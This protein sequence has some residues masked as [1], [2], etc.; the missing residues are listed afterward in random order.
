MKANSKFYY[1]VFIFRHALLIALFMISDNA[2]PQIYGLKFQNHDVVLDKR[3]EL[4]LSPDRFLNFNGEFE[5]SFDFNIYLLKPNDYSGLFG[6]IFRIIS[7]ENNNIDLLISPNPTI[8]LNLVIG[9]TDSVIHIG[10][11]NNALDGWINLRVKFLLNE[12]RLIFYTP[13]SFY[14]QENVGFKRDDSF[15]IIF[16][17]NDYGNFKTSDVPSMIIKDIRISEEGNLKYHW[18]LDEEE[19]N[20]AGNRLNKAVALVKNPIWIKNNHCKWETRY[21]DEINGYVLVASDN[22]NG[23]IFLVGDRE[24]LIYSAQENIIQSVKYL[25]KS[26]SINNN[27]S[28]IYNSLDN[29]IYC[30]IIN[31]KVFYSLDVLTGEWTEIDAYSNSVSFYRHY[32]SF[33]N[34]DEN[35]IYIFGGYGQHSYHNEIRKLDLTK[36][37]WQDLTVDNDI[38]FPRYLTGLG[39]LNDTVYLLGGFGSLTGSQLVNPHSFFDLL[40]YSIKNRAFFKKFE[41]TRIYDDM[42]VGNTMWINNKNRDYYALIFEKI[43]FESS[44]QLIKGNI[45][46]PKVKFLGDRIPFKFLD[47]RSNASLFYFPDQKKLFAY[48]SFVTDSATTLVSIYSIDHPPAEFS[49]GNL[50]FKTRKNLLLILFTIILVISSPFL[51]L[52]IIR[53]RRSKSIS[54]DEIEPDAGGIDKESKKPAPED[55]SEKPNYQLVLF[56]GFQVFNRNDED[57]TNKF[58]PLLKELFLL[59][60]LYTYKNNKG[61]TSDQISEYLWFG[62]STLSARNN[63]AVNIAKLKAILSELGAVELTKKTGYWKMIFDNDIVKSDYHDFLEISSS[64]SNLTRLNICRLLEITKQ[65]GFLINTNYEWLDDFKSDISDKIID[66][67]VAFTEKCKL[68][69]DA[70]FII[71]L[72]DCIFNFD[73]VNEEAMVL[74]CKAECFL[75]NH[76]LA[77][78]TYEK[79]VREYQ[80]LYDEEFET[81]F[82]EL[83]KS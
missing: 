29:K 23:K 20:K 12:D 53:K 18:P 47:V 73:K 68:E 63:R 56:G 82:N 5:I 1:F 58:S 83:I 74:K 30:Y 52:Y 10:S 67:M 35:S 44:L 28:S 50:N 80:K 57:I 78:M 8:N 45:D 15:R 66:T 24:L 36:N 25:D 77:K 6:Y 13:D 42:C 49:V 9:R 48:T 2:F 14:V 61:I 71:H 38:F 40:G 60:L 32:N 37:G 79:F 69:T 65:G 72:A 75:G 26:I 62:K 43:K 64:K 3:T 81:S 46:N 51:S 27:F 4:N 59:I 17:A 31:N 41:I 39:S 22:E 7:R 21:Q 11:I 55:P 19:G 70:E 34:P 16:G 76:S 33:F 54:Q